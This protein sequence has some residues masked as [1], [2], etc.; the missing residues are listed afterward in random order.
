MAIRLI[1]KDGR[2]RVV[3]DPE[4]EQEGLLEAM[5]KRLLEKKPREKVEDVPEKFEYG[6]AEALFQKLGEAKQ[7][8]EEGIQRLREADPKDFFLL[9]SPSAKRGV[10]PITKYIEEKIPRFQID[11]ER[12]SA[13]MLEQMGEEQGGMAGEFWMQQGA[14]QRFGL[15]ATEF[16]ANLPGEIIKDP[17]RTIGKWA[18]D[19]KMDFWD[20]AN[21]IDIATTP[22]IPE[23]GIAGAMVKGVR[24]EVAETG[25]RQAAEEVAPTATKKVKGLLPGKSFKEFKGFLGEVT[26]RTMD[27]FKDKTFV[28][29]QEFVD[30]IKKI[31]ASKQE[32]NLMTEVLEGVPRLDDGR[33]PVREWADRLEPYLVELEPIFSKNY[34]TMHPGKRPVMEGLA[35]DA[36]GEK[37]E[38]YFKKPGNTRLP[39]FIDNKKPEYFETIYQAPYKTNVSS[40]DWNE[41]TDQYFSH[42]RSYGFRHDGKK[43]LFDAELQNDLFQ[44]DRYK[45]LYSEKAQIRQEMNQSIP[46]VNTKKNEVK[47]LR[48]AKNLLGNTNVQIKIKSMLTGAD[49]R[50][51]GTVPKSDGSA[52]YVVKRF[53]M[54]D[55]ASG[56]FTPGMVEGRYDN[57]LDAEDALAAYKVDKDAILKDIKKA[58]KD[59]GVPDEQVD[60][61]V[62]ASESGATPGDIDDAIKQLDE[63]L[64]KEEEMLNEWEGNLAKKKTQ[65][66]E[67]EYGS[68]D[69]QFKDKF[70]DNYKE[71]YRERIIKERIKFAA[72]NGYDELWMPKGKT[73]SYM[74]GHTKLPIQEKVIAKGDVNV[75]K[76]FDDPK[77]ADPYETYSYHVR[78]IDGDKITAIR[79][80][81]VVDEGKPEEFIDRIVSRTTRDRRN[82]L[83]SSL[84]YPEDYDLTKK[85]AEKLVKVYLRYLEKD[86][87]MSPY[88]RRKLIKENKLLDLDAMTQ[89]MNDYSARK[90]KSKKDEIKPSRLSI[91]YTVD[92]V[93][94]EVWNTIY[95]PDEGDPII[96]DTDWAEDDAEYT[97][98]SIK[99]KLVAGRTDMLPARLHKHL[100]LENYG[101]VFRDNTLNFSNA[102]IRKDLGLGDTPTVKQAIKVLK[103]QKPDYD[104]YNWNDKI[105]QVRKDATTKEFNINDFTNPFKKFDPDTISGTTPGATKPSAHSG[106]RRIYEGYETETPEFVRRLEGLESDEF[107]D[108]QGFDYTRLKI[109]PEQAKKKIPALGLLPIMWYLKQQGGEQPQEGQ[110]EDKM[111]NQFMSEGM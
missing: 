56:K 4:G 111:L 91:D 8:A 20:Y 65:Y 87:L 109:T 68:P 22:G 84:S 103:K 18:E 85:E 74:Q 100:G 107:M 49:K 94:D 38:T 2:N 28:T 17:I 73:G 12:E 102:N 29:E 55:M 15:G 60:E 61:I 108:A 93:D 27:E 82:F 6:S 92:E 37:F 50:F 39:A 83:S 25:L 1:G 99:E 80:S 106:S 51:I 26:L 57:L 21:M 7:F 67:M 9:T 24:G 110:L 69:E 42:V 101:R 30:T 71:L 41:I 40:H 5:R 46:K 89:T 11:P 58:A 96:L 79:R 48:K 64:V 66:E 16:V 95:T 97:L 54:V 35:D 31:D 13:K 52:E 14:K 75:G 98:E 77:P 45:G 53:G 70:L 34:Y 86:N 76:M 44:Q 63:R 3:E 32:R 78:D 81:S 59:Y 43:I 10:L 90:L 47:Q 104:F 33:I 36:F 88:L 72:E 23:M 62:K 19:K 105:Y